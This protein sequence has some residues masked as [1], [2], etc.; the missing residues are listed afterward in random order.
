MFLSIKQA[1]SVGLRNFP[2][3]KKLCFGTSE[4]NRFIDLLLRLN[5][6]ESMIES[7]LPE[8]NGSPQ[9]VGHAKRKH[10]RIPTIHFQGSQLDVSFRGG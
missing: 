4:A 6:E 7:T 9:K 1:Q 8:T 10:P 5:D 2:M 3:K